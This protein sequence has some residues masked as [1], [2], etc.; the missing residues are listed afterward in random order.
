MEEK[1]EWKRKDGEQ[2]APVRDAEVEHLDDPRVRERPQELELPARHLGEVLAHGLHLLQR[3]A[4]LRFD[5]SRTR[6][7]KKVLFTDSVSVVATESKALLVLQ[8]PLC[9]SRIRSFVCKAR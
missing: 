2:S 9:C 7:W 6:C 3:R 8:H 1:S 4:Y 5:W